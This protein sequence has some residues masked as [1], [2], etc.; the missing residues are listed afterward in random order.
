MR[1]RTNGENLVAESK[2][3]S[4]LEMQ[5]LETL[6]ATPVQNNKTSLKSDCSRGSGLDSEGQAPGKHIHNSKA[7]SDPAG[8][9]VPPLASPQTQQEQ[10]QPRQSPAGPALRPADTRLT[11]QQLPPKP[12][13]TGNWS[14]GDWSPP[15]RPRPSAWSMRTRLTTQRPVR[16]VTPAINRSWEPRP[17]PRLTPAPPPR[18]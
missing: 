1:L 2:P 18:S 16:P 8:S 5:A 15:P 17:N 7:L 4:T 11:H 6:F 10:P 12:R 13:L 14:R 9:Q 3:Q